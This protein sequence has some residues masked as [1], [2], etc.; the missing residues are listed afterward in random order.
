MTG[1]T[2][3]LFLLVGLFFG[4]SY[5]LLILTRGQKI[6]KAN[7]KQ[8]I[9]VVFATF[10]TVAVLYLILSALPILKMI[11]AILAIVCAYGTFYALFKKYYGT[12]VKQSLDVYLNAIIATVIVGVVLNLFLQGTIYQTFYAPDTAMSPSV[13]KDDMLLIDKLSRDFHREDI[14]LIHN[15]KFPQ[16]LLLERVIAVPTDTIELEKDH[17]MLNG[18]WKHERYTTGTFEPS[19]TSTKLEPDHY[20]LLD[21]NRTNVVDSRVFG[22]VSNDQIIGKAFL[23]KRDAHIEW[24]GDAI[25][26][27]PE[28]DETF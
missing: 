22:P 7:Y 26:Q 20:F 10:V 5:A 17:V 2:L 3:F 11:P 18:K 8:S 15:P 16:Q 23:L 19:N 21:D 13:V 9:V 25:E 27:A 4:L 14:V 12:T 24:I 6:E 1:S 28:K